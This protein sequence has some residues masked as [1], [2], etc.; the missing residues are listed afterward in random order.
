MRR[1]P[2]TPDF[3]QV[4]RAHSGALRAFARS[5]TGEHHLA[6]DVVQE[7]FLRAWRHLPS[8]RGDGPLEAWLVTICRNVALSMLTRRRTTEPLEEDRPSTADDF[9]EADLL[10]M[11]SHLDVDH[12]EVAALCLVLAWPY[13]DVAAALGVPVGT[14]RSRLSRARD[15]L[16]AMLDTDSGAG[17]RSSGAA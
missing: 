6:E 4:V 17:R 16:R 1:A 7:T 12:R 8:W 11:I 3:E 2:A 9:A 15:N 13:A 14:V 10:E 5:M